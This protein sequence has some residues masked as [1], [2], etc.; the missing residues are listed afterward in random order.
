MGVLSSKSGNVSIVTPQERFD[1]NSAPDV[2]RVISENIE[3]GATKIVIDLSQIAYLSSMGLRVIFKTVTTM[4]RKDGKVALCGGN[5]QVLKVLQ[6]S[7]AM[8][9]TLHVPTLEEA[10]K[11]IQS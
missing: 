10:V 5:D 4:M 8:I 6:L 2:E 7:G 11:K 9:S 3:S 1:T